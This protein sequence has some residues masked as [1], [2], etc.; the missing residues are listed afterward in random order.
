MER[1]VFCFIFNVHVAFLNI[2]RILELLSIIRELTLKCCLAWISIASSDIRRA[3]RN[4]EYSVMII[5]SKKDYI[6]NI[7]VVLG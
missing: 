7:F 1:L 6:I 4:Y 5:T 3:E 2:T